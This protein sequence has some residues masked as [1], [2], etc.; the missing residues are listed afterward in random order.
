MGFLVGLEDITLCQVSCPWTGVWRSCCELHYMKHMKSTVTRRSVSMHCC[1]DSFASL[2]TRCSSPW[3]TSKR[4][5]RDVEGEHEGFAKTEYTVGARLFLK[6]WRPRA[7][8]YRGDKLN[9]CSKLV[10]TLP[11][12]RCHGGSGCR[13]G[14]TY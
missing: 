12:F 10:Y 7:N 4:T 13:P 11:S 2:K 5:H 14:Y 9:R 3:R 8:F 6:T 1:Q